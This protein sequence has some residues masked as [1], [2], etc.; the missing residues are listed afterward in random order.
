MSNWRERV[1][2][3]NQLIIEYPGWG[4]RRINAQL[5]VEFG[6][7]LRDASVDALTRPKRELRKAGITP[8][9]VAPRPTLPKLWLIMKDAGFLRFEIHGVKDSPATP[10]GHIRPGKER[11]YFRRV[12]DRMIRSRRAEYQSFLKQAQNT[13]WSR[14]KTSRRWQKRIKG[15]YLRGKFPTVGGPVAGGGS[16]VT[17]DGNPSPWSLYRAWEAKLIKE[18]PFGGD[19][20]GTPRPERRRRRKDAVKRFVPPSKIRKEIAENRRIIKEL[21]ASIARQRSAGNQAMV[22]QHIQQ[23]GYRVETLNKLEEQLK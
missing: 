9:I 14:S 4:R 8:E 1:Y 6:R 21:D 17:A 3:A 16:F 23:R 11:P 10:L 5:R 13:G 7:G 15:H 18:A 20:W 22:K 19:A 12:L 2:R